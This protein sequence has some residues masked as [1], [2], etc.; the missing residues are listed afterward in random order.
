[1]SSEILLKNAA[2]KAIYC[3]FNESTQLLAV[4]QELLKSFAQTDVMIKLNPNSDSNLIA[5]LNEII[6]KVWPVPTSTIPV[7]PEQLRLN[8]YYVLFGFTVSGK[9][10]SFSKP[11]SYY[12]EFV[13]TLEAL[14]EN[15]VDGI[16]ESKN[17]TANTSR[18]ASL[19]Q[20]LTR[21]QTN[22]IDRTNNLIETTASYWYD[23][24]RV[25]LTSNLLDNDELMRLLN[26]S[27]G[28]GRN[29]DTRGLN[30]KRLKE[31]FLGSTLVTGSPNPMSFFNIPNSLPGSP[32]P[33][34]FPNFANSVSVSGS[35]ETESYFD[36]ADTMSKFIDNI[37]NTKK[38]TT[39]SAAH[40]YK[41]ENLKLMI[42]AWGR[43]TQKDLF[44]NAL[45]LRNRSV[46]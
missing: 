28:N 16:I 38:W 31:K 39:E 32:N 26:I 9:D 22:L 11:S 45:A 42:D 3:Y 21:L 35:Q 25:N 17:A 43:V 10:A 33:M 15:L 12:Q 41:D 46:I 13:T 1:M 8:L 29:N 44:A 2:S 27:S 36:L 34:S 23:T 14:L 5:T 4:A 24:F 18:P 40:L 7:T 30:L 19:A 20:L 6:D 37:I